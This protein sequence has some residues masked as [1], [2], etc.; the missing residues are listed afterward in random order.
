MLIL[1]SVFLIISFSIS[2]IKQ[3]GFPTRFHEL[4]N[5][6]KFRLEHANFEKEYDYNNFSKKKNIL[7][8]G[9]SV[10]EDLQRMFYFSEEINKN[11]Y[12][13]VFS[14]KKRPWTKNY[15]LECFK[16]FY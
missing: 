11:Y 15:Q 14:P 4:L 2:S 5:I 8:L 12:S 9:N 6:Q 16:V 7:I 1:L 10:A 13:Y 3:N